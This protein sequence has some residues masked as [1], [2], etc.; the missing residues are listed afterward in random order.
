MASPSPHESGAGSPRPEESSKRI[1]LDNTIIPA[2]AALAGALIGAAVSVIITVYQIKANQHQ[3]VNDFLRS[4]REA[5][6]STFLIDSNRLKSD[7][8]SYFYEHA[9]DLAPKMSSLFTKLNG[10]YSNLVIIGPS[11]VSDQSL[12]VV[13]SADGMI[14]YQRLGPHYR[15]ESHNMNTATSYFSDY[16]NALDKLARDM[17]Q[18]VENN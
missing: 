2:V 5:S 12:K 18:V 9:T 17:S 7:W 8:N 10:D 14:T 4:Q 16:S 3:A 1:R 6:Y 15:S 11:S 13:T